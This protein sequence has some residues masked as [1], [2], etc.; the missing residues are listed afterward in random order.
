MIALGGM[1]IAT[2]IR[3]A[4]KRDEITA[5]EAKELALERVDELAGTGVSESKLNEMDE[6]YPILNLRE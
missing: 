2:E 6:L 3:L 1:K 4:L 5:D